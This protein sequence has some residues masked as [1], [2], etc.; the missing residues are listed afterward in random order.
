VRR[1]RCTTGTTCSLSGASVS[2]FSGADPA[3]GP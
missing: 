1:S 2:T 3:G